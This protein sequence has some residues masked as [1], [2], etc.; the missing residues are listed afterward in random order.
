M[1]FAMTVR[2]IDEQAGK[3]QVE[4][5]NTHPTRFVSS[6]NWTPPAGMHVTRLTSAYGGKCR[7]STD[8]I[9]TCTGLA[10]PPTS[11]QGV[12]EGLIIN[13]VADGRQP[14]FENGYWIH[15]GVVGA[16]QVTTSKFSDLPVCKKG[17]KNTSAHPCASF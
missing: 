1:P 8:G 15:Y 10:A 3:Y 2:I 4:I 6:F 17:Q 16:V 12:G 13:F 11:A 9:I 14:T 7:L 5:D